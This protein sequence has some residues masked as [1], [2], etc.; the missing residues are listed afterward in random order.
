VILSV[1]DMSK[2]PFR[3]A[4]FDIVLC[5]GAIEYAEDINSVVQQIS[6]VLK[7]KGYLIISMQNKNSIYRW[8]DIHIYRSRVINGA[9]KI[10][11][12]PPMEKPLENI[13]SLK[14]FQKYFINNQFKITD[15][16]FY[17]FNIFIK[18]FDRRLAKAS[19]LFRKNSSGIMVLS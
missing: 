16:V 3:D 15:V 4:S 18:P 10:I 7:H 19:V 13:F 5:L 12:R 2:L 1:A 8:W 11:G 14:E 17:D 9:K 6:R